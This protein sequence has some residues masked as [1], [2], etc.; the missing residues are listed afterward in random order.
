M[1]PKLDCVEKVLRKH[2]NGDLVAVDRSEDFIE[3]E[4]MKLLE[5]GIYL[6]VKLSYDLKRGLIITGISSSK[7]IV[8][9]EQ[10]PL[11]TFKDGTEKYRNH[12]YIIQ[13]LKKLNN[14]I[15]KTC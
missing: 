12:P 13:L 1:N 9:G 4:D 2:I 14:D 15:Q 8:I 3:A 11:P 5:S 10:P 7:E 6:D